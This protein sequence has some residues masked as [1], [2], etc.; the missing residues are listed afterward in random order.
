MAINYEG[1]KKELARIF[2]SAD[3]ERKIVF[4]Y[5]E[6]KNF[7]EDIKV[8]TFAHAK[9]VL[10]NKN[11]FEIKHLLEVED[12]ESNYLLYFPIK[13]PLDN[14]NW[15]LDILLYS[16][17]YYADTVAL[18]MRMLD[19]SNSEL[20]RV[21]SRHQNFFNNKQRIEKLKQ[22]VKLN[23]SLNQ[24]E[25]RN[26]MIAV[27]V[28]S[29]FINIEYILRELVFDFDTS[30]KYEELLKYG[31][32]DYLWNQISDYA[33]YTGQQSIKELIKKFMMTTVAKSSDLKEFSGF[34][35]QYIIEDDNYESG[36]EDALIFVHN[37]KSDDRYEFLQEK[38][39]LELRIEEFL[40][41]RG[42]KDITYCDVFEVFD[43]YIIKSII[44]SLNQGSLDFTFFDK[45]IRDF[46]INS[47]WYDKNHN[48]YDFI[49]NAMQFMKT[50]DTYITEGLKNTEYV[51]EY[52]KTL[53][54]IDTFYRKTI[55]SYKAIEE[56]TDDLEELI[57]RLDNLYEN[58]FLSRLGDCFSKSLEADSNWSFPGLLMV[59]DFYMEIQRTPFKKMFVI[60]SDG[61]RY[62]VGKELSETIISDEKLKGTVEIKP[63]ISLLPSD[64]RFGMAALLPHSS[65]SYNNKNVFVDG[66]STAGTENRRK[67][68]KNKNE[69]FDVIT[70]SQINEMAGKDLR[71][72]MSDKTLVYIYHNAID[73]AGEHNED[74]VFEAS[75]DAI[76]EITKL[77]RKLYN[78]LQYSNFYITAD[79]GFLYRRKPINNHHKYDDIVSLKLNE[80]SKRYLISENPVA[81]PYTLKYEMD[82]LGENQVVIPYSND[83]FKTQGGGIQYI[84]GGASLQEVVIP[85]IKVSELRADRYKDIGGPVGVRL[86]SVQRKITNRSFTLE[87]EQYE[88]IEEKKKER[89]IIVKFIDEN[90]NSVSSEYH[91]MANSTSDSPESRV[92]KLRL[93]LSN[94]EFDRNNRYFLEMRD[95][96]T[97]E[98]LEKEQFVID[99]LGFKAII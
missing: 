92:T 44:H 88:K 19:L 87:F 45:V 47:K 46:R 66:M 2:S 53:S 90:G 24:N 14:G 25:L 56:K 65:I 34:Y 58:K 4:W 50:V 49:L 72:F 7:I 31:F 93:A 51:N 57:V 81:I 29:K 78:V 33:N 95:S 16:E 26:A 91:F 11:S 99:I 89:S 77:I 5:D 54:D 69:S 79:H 39:S 48:S 75:N 9:V 76:D 73:N 71:S 38:L 28:K 63:M 43:K 80:T 70:Y 27:L 35:K 22:L 64:T 59:T 13:K 55:T 36:V 8:D 37:L 68:M 41:P 96:E 17:E 32:E 67:V 1:V 83:I 30:V 23:D 6:P 84:H 94:T 40:V 74:K 20:R 85:L 3:G 21:I 42:I 61:L 18:T 60:I 15:L 12:K 52:T 86:K 98:I 82:Y 62:E 10:Y 97:K